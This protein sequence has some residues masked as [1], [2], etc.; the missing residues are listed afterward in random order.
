MSDIS[1][2]IPTLNRDTLLMRTLESIAAVISP[3]D[4]VEILLVDN[5]STDQSAKVFHALK[6]KFSELEWRYFYDA[7]PGLLSG[8]HRGA[9]EA[10]GE[11]LAYLDDDALL[12]PTWLEALK[13]AFR[14]PGVGLVGG[15]SLPLFEVDPPPWLGKLWWDFDGGRTCG[16][17]SLIELGKVSKPIDPCYVWG[18]NFSIRK[19]VFHECGGFHPDCVPKSLQRYQGDGETGLTLK[20]KEKRIAALYHPGVAVTHVIPTS[21][22]T[23]E[24]FEQRAFYQGVCDSYTRIRRDRFVPDPRQKSWKDLLRPAKWNLERKMILRNPTSENIRY[25]MGRA[26]MAGMQFHQDEVRNDQ[27]LFAWIIKPDYLDY[28]LPDGWKDYE[29]QPRGRDL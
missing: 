10:Q 21:R 9:E 12:A 29:N 19:E 4:A 8:R 23:P 24:A 22:L 25:L 20:A 5:G 14:D 3:K 26:H 18:L 27:R 11:I 16:S 17:L 7:M 2:I 15:P 6:E 28:R 1:I 13:D